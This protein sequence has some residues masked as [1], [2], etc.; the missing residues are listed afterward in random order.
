MWRTDILT[1]DFI[2]PYGTYSIFFPGS[3][4]ETFPNSHELYY[5]PN[6]MDFFN[7]DRNQSSSLSFLYRYS[8]VGYSESN[9]IS[10]IWYI[11]WIKVDPPWMNMLSKDLRLFRHHGLLG[12]GLF[13]LVSYVHIPK[14]WYICLTQTTSTICRNP[15]LNWFLK[16]FQTNTRFKILK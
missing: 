13:I 4:F 14:P 7:W 5:Q 6:N 15:S 9:M 3:I 1:T 16:W 10:I 12:C 11:Q 2:V 8:G